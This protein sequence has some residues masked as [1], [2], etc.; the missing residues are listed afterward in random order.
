MSAYERVQD[1]APPQPGQAEDAWQAAIAAYLTRYWHMQAPGVSPCLCAANTT[2]LCVPIPADG[3][4][5]P[6][7]GITVAYTGSVTM[8]HRGRWH[9][10]GGAGRAPHG[11]SRGRRGIAGGPRGR[12]MS[13]Y[14][15][16]H[17]A[18]RVHKIL[19]LELPQRG[20]VLLSPWR[21]SAQSAR[22]IKGLH[23]LEQV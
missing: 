23:W 7:N 17:E 11:A 15:P 8:A 21:P 12:P 13:A 22:A 16:R 2:R 1:G 4:R 5:L 20:V 6:V 9:A 19:K 14:E 10:A 18:Q 3:G